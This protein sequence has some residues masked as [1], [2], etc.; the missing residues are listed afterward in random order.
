MRVCRVQACPSAVPLPLSSLLMYMMSH[1]SLLLILHFLWR[2]CMLEGVLVFTHTPAKP[3]REQSEG[4]SLIE[5]VGALYGR[6][7]GI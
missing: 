3:G 2:A 5:I 1:L 7:G 4:T 6:A